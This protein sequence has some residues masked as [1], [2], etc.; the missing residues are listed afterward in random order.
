MLVLIRQN[1]PE[2][3]EESLIVVKYFELGV[4]EDGKE[5]KSGE[6]LNFGNQID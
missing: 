2:L 4:K 3:N 5:K 6:P 1:F